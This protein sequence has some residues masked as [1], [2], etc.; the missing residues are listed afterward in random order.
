[1]AHDAGGLLLLSKFHKL[2][3][4]EKEEVIGCHDEKVVIE[5]Q[6]FDGK[7][8]IAYGTKTGFIGLRSVIHDDHGFTVMTVLLP[9]LEDGGKLMIGD[10]DVL[11]DVGDG[12]NVTK[13]AVENG[14]FTNLQQG[15]RCVARQLA[16]TRGV[17]SCND[18]C[19]HVLYLSRK[20]CKNSE[21][22]ENNLFLGGRGG[23]REL[24]ENGEKNENI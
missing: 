10:D 21:R 2:A 16:Q 11:C 17:S 9:R 20:Y 18:Y 15:F 4:R 22:D 8:Q 12:V 3:E 24:C 5:M 6:G 19:L 23:L 1:M 14:V 7:E 13:Q